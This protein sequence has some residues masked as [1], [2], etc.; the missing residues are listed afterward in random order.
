MEQVDPFRFQQNY[1]HLKL[2]RLD[3]KSCILFVL[4]FGPE[5]TEMSE[6]LPNLLLINTVHSLFHHLKV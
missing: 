2:E 3:E 5:I 6:I 4:D 1:S